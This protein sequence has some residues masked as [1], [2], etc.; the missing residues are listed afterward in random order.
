MSL[1]V[2]MVAR[3]LNTGHVRGMGRYVQELLLR[4]AD[5]P[6]L[7][8]T[9]FGN[10]PSQPLQAR[11]GP[12]IQADIFEFRGDRFD[13]WEQI[14]LPRR[15]RSRQVDVLHCTEG[16]LPWWQP[17]PTVVTVHD[18]LAWQERPD[19]PWNR[20]YWDRLLPAA[21]HRCAAV[22]TISESSK[23]DIVA[24][25]PALAAKTTVIPHGIGDEYLAADTPAAASELQ[26]GLGTCPYLVYVGGP[27]ARKRFDWALQVLHAC[28]R[29]DLQLVACGFGSSAVGAARESVPP[30]LRARVHFAP[31]LSNEQLLALYRGARAV[32][33]PTLYEGFGFPAIEAQAAGVPVVFSPVSSLT[34]LV[35]PL[36]LLAPADEMSTWCARV[37]EAVGLGTHRAELAQAARTWARQFSWVESA[38]KHLAVYQQVAAQCRTAAH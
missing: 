1:H 20:L 14:G 23:R 8:W 29:D 4:S 2:G 33:Y 9:L 7:R 28:G 32:L 11:T 3:C 19:T 15:A 36:A 6:G 5:E 24:K 35:G 18:T 13:L 10:D 21:L 31:F 12:A 16:A 26:R 34:E 37:H 17:V 30:G 27:M 22:I 25:W 38:R